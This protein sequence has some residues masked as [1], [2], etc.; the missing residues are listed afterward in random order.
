VGAAPGTAGPMRGA[1]LPCAPGI[2]YLTMEGK[3]RLV[4]TG[5]AAWGWEGSEAMIGLVNSVA[6]Y[7][8][9]REQAAQ[10]TRAAVATPTDLGEPPMWVRPH[11]EQPPTR[12]EAKAVTG[13]SPQ[14]E[15][16]SSPA[17]AEHARQAVHADAGSTGG[18]VGH[19][20]DVSA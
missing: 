13:A 20:L 5:R 10:T 4:L 11:E 18:G 2:S 12:F 9:S 15:N 6:A 14:A 17:P 7:P 19:V 1:H 3:F 16:P 8:A